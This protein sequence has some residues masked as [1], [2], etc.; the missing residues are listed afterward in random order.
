M[1]LQLICDILAD[2]LERDPGSIGPMSTFSSLGMDDM[3]LMELEM[4]LEETYDKEMPDGALNRMA[5][6]GEVATYVRHWLE[7]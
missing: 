5:T 7:T 4:E 2:M 6:V 3:D 1:E